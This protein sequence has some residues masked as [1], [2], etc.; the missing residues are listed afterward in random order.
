M[1][2]EV[3]YGG[4]GAGSVRE[5]LIGKRF[6]RWTVVAIATDGNAA[7]RRLECRCDCGVMRALYERKLKEGRSK[8]CGCAKNAS[9]MTDLS[10]R[11]FGEVTVVSRAGTKMRHNG[12]TSVWH[13]QCSCGQQFTVARDSIA[14]KRCGTR[15]CKNG[16]RRRTGARFN[17]F[18]YMVT[19]AEL[20]ELSGK[21]APTITFRMDKL[22]LCPVAAAFS[23]RI[24][25]GVHSRRR[26]SA[27]TPATAARD[28]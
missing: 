10:G 22:G 8:S 15:G 21:L 25:G 2:G 1:R 23:P 7:V 16:P 3:W 17:I 13:C 18:G 5:S 9:H 28:T 4:S 14:E 6:G 24:A 19:L 27:A 11:V 20:S 26:H 12:P